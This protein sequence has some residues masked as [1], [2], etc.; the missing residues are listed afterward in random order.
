MK[1]INVIKWL[2]ELA[3]GKPI[4]FS[5]VILMIAV[6]TMAKVIVNRDGKIDN[7]SVEKKELSRFYESRIDSINRINEIKVTNLNIELRQT[8]LN[9][10]DDSKEALEEQKTLN[11]KINTTINKTSKL[12]KTNKDRVKNLRR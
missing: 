4:V 1:S 12:I 5:V 10:I 9:I 7:C 8:L 2:S 3:D 11:Q 6:F